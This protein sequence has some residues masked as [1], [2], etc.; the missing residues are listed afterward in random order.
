MPPVQYCSG[1]SCA[2]DC[3]ANSSALF[4][5]APNLPLLRC[6]FL[7]PLPVSTPPCHKV[8]NRL[9][10]AAKNFG[11]VDYS[12]GPRAGR[13]PAAHAFCAVQSGGGWQ[14]G[15]WAAGGC[16]GCER[17]RLAF[18]LHRRVKEGTKGNQ[19]FSGWGERDQRSQGRLAPSPSKTK[20]W[21]GG[22]RLPTPRVVSMPHGTWQGCV[23][24]LRFLYHSAS[25]SSS[26][27]TQCCTGSGGE[28][29]FCL[30]SY[31]VELDE[32]QHTHR[33]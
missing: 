27:S 20:T 29:Q 9:A 23:R 15:W 31:D 17:A 30:C 12:G 2:N 22:E 16:N 3:S 21:R 25:H 5:A 4:T 18:I 14:A 32:Q 6:C 33:C 13:D 19:M 24:E 1:C 10:N 26:S 7:R 8:S 11:V 28:Q